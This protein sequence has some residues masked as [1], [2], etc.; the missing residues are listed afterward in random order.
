MK[1]SIIDGKN[2]FKEIEVNLEDIDGISKNRILRTIF[3][4]KRKYRLTLASYKK[5]RSFDKKYWI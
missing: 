2:G 1:I 4:N 5:L 3:I